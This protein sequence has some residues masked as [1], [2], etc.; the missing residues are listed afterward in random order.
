[1]DRRERAEEPAQPIRY[2]GEAVV[3]GVNGIADFNA[4]HSRS[5]EAATGAQQAAFQLGGQLL[6]VMLDP[7]VDGRAN[8]FAARPVCNPACHRDR[9]FEMLSSI[10]GVRGAAGAESEQHNRALPGLVNAV[11]SVL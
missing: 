6:N 5:G 7:F 4:L 1:M 2:C 11:L 9:P 10:F 3:L 8:A